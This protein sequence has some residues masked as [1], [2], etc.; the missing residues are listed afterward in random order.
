M[1]IR[2]GFFNSLN[3]DRLYN[4]DDFNRYFEG[5]ISQN[6]VFE[7]YL[8]GMKVSVN[9]NGEIVVGTGK[10]LV[11]RTWIELDSAEVV[12][13]E[14]A[15]TLYPRYDA[16]VLRKSYENREITLE[17]IKGNSKTNPA[18]YTP[19]RTA[20]IY[21][22]VLADIYIE[23]EAT[24][25]TANNIFDERPYKDKCGM[26]VVL[27][28]Q[29]DIGDIY[30]MYNSAF[31]KMYDEFSDWK[32]EQQ[33]QFDKWYSDLTHSLNVD[34]SLREY[35]NSV[36]QSSGNVRILYLSEN[37][38][39]VNYQKGDALSVYVNGLKLVEDSD[40]DY[41]ILYDSEYQDYCVRFN[42]P[43]TGEATIEVVNLKSE[44][45]YNPNVGYLPA[46]NVMA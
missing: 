30:N 40:E 23:A 44:V 43:I 37:G 31:G 29:P 34:T 2:Y 5:L 18:K 15:D 28:D 4:A 6:G 25:I 38:M 45:G 17:V 35:K 22:I 46:E 12:T 10:A 11:D 19:K 41:V 7:N 21:E 3:G 26:I 8:E 20:S 33:N 1:A 39:N 42:E 24:S 14:K 13:V 27:V 32:K 36:W 9:S 16:I